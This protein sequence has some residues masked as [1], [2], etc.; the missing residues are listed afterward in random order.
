MAPRALLGGGAPGE[1]ELHLLGEFRLQGGCRLPLPAQ[2]V[3]AF[4]A[5]NDGP[6]RR[7]LVAEQL[8]PL[9]HA[10]AALANLRQAL[11]QERQAGRRLIESDRADLTL[12]PAVSID[13]RY[14]SSQLRTR[15]GLGDRLVPLLVDDLL[16]GWH[17]DWLLPIQERYR[18]LRLHGLHAIAEQALCE[19]R[20]SDAIDAALTAISSDPFHERPRALLIRAYL[21]ER[22]LA[23]ARREYQSYHRL[24]REELQETPSEELSSLIRLGD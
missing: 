7:D 14:V 22:N 19:D 21:R 24:L 23:A 13:Y 3:V 15:E 5:V 11:H 1:F 20:L 10:G 8:W 2:R 6:H 4:L 17:D 12:A 9:R 18:Q 16:P